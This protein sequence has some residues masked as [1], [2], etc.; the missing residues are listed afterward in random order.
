MNEE[1]TTDLILT[2]IFVIGF[3]IWSIGVPISIIYYLTQ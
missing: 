1:K 2:L 3:I